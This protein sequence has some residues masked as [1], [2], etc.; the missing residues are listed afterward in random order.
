MD[1]AGAGAAVVSAVSIVEDEQA[2]TA[3]KRARTLKERRG[4]HFID[5]SVA[6]PSSPKA[7]PDSAAQQNGP[8]VMRAED[9]STYPDIGAGNVV[10]L[11]SAPVPPSS[12]HIVPV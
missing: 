9:R 12:R 2:P 6:H 5:S 3:N 11:V 1:V 8:N 4:R 10:V 7:E